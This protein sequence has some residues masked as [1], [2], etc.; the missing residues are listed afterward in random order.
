MTFKKTLIVRV[1]RVQ[2]FRKH[3]Q[4]QIKCQKDDLLPKKNGVT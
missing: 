4:V 1:C 3:K 2:E